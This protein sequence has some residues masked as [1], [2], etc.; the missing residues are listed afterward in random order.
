[1]RRAN[2]MLVLLMPLFSLAPPSAA[3]VLMNPDFDTNVEHW[4]DSPVGG[5]TSVLWNA[6]DAGDDPNSGSLRLETSTYFDGPQ[7]DC[8]AITP[9][10][11]YDVRAMIYVPTQPNPPIAT[12]AAVFYDNPDCTD[13]RQVIQKDFFD[14]PFD[15]WVDIG[16]LAITW[17][18]VTSARVWLFTDNSSPDG[19][20]VAYFDDVRLDLLPE[21]DAFMAGAIAMASLA[22]LRRRRG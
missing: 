18:T 1:M 6:L 20:R 9:L 21:P 22:A 17:S 5:T 14:Q 16:G 4:T 10:T 15:T 8:V 7:S 19:T 3:V 13:G 11:D 2:R 12:V